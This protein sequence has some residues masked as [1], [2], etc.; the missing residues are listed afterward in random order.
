MLKEWYPSHM[1]EL[2]GHHP[3]EWF[4]FFK[5]N[6]EALKQMSQNVLGLR[7]EQLL[8]GWYHGHNLLCVCDTDIINQTLVIKNVLVVSPKFHWQDFFEML[9][10]AGKSRRLDHIFIPIIKD[11][12]FSA[13]PLFDLG[14]KK[15]K[16]SQGEGYSYSLEYHTGIVL[17]G[18]G[19]KGAYQIGAW[20]ALR[21]IGIDYQV[22]TG[23]SV[24]ALNGAFFVQGDIEN[25]KIMW[26]DIDT[27]KILAI[28]TDEEEE[29]NREHLISGVKSL[30][31]SALKENGVDT[32]PLL[33]MITKLIDPEKLEQTDKDFFF[34]TTQAPKMEETVVSLKETPANMLNRWLLASS[35]FYPAMSACEIDGH[36]YVDGGY[37]NNIP[38]DVALKQNV[39]EL[40]VINVK[41]P[42]FLKPTRVPKT[43][44]ETDI[45]TRWGLGAVLLFDKDRST[46]NIKQGYFDTMKAFYKLQGT[47]YTFS[48]EHFK[49]NS[50]ALSKEFL[51]FIQTDPN[52][53]SVGRKVTWKWLEQKQIAPETLGVYLLEET[54]KLLDVDP[55]RL[56]TFDELSKEV[57]TLFD[58]THVTPDES[59]LL[60]VGEM[61]SGYMKQATPLSEM[62]LL[63]MAYHLCESHA[64]NLAHVFDVTWKTMLQA[65]FI[66]FLKEKKQ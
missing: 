34:I 26:E 39:S 7:D 17:G 16:T 19:A 65:M 36:Y 37:R 2:K 22:V 48:N 13:K 44:V 3:K 43:V 29:T 11:P 4:P 49:K 14:F 25:A 28:P 18:G 46:W 50:L 8:F 15:E 59:M 20:E 63:E 27:S 53:K 61:L 6:Q 9:L 35:S 66:I 64:D 52:L 47:W 21:E 54:A 45:E 24:G 60:S 56:F 10:H 57:I 41:G 40:I 42:G 30:T 55:T 12:I 38:R 32:T 51:H 33:D 23:T 5:S 1:Q 31:L 58:K 62:K